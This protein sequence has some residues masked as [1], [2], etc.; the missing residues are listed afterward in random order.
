[1]ASLTAG[2][3]PSL[4]EQMQS[5]RLDDQVARA[6]EELWLLKH[7]VDD[8]ADA[9]WNNPAAF[10]LPNTPDTHFCIVH[11]S[12]TAVVVGFC[13]VQWPPLIAMATALGLGAHVYVGNGDPVNPCSGAH[14]VTQM[15]AARRRGLAL[16]WA[17]EAPVP[18]CAAILARL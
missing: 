5:I 4:S 14:L 17:N 3:A 15:D 9:F 10:R 16:R 2:H 1:M 13:L 7:M 11:A 18:P 12:T 8:D 6:T